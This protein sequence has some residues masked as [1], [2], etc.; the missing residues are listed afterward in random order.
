MHNYLYTTV[1]PA[2]QASK[3]KIQAISTLPDNDSILTEPT[4]RNEPVA[5]VRSSNDV[6]TSHPQGYYII[7]STFVRKAT[8]QRWIN[9]HQGET[10]LNDARILESDGHAKI[11]V[12]SCASSEEASHFL[13]EFTSSHPE[14]A[15]AWIYSAKND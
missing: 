13:N 9:E 15:S 1:K 6:V 8:A 2:P 5:Q 10:V 14:Y 3:T 11:F 12:K 4:T 7:V